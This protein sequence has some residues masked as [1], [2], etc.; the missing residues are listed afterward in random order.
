MP[1]LKFFYAPYPGDV[2]L[3]PMALVAAINTMNGR[4][5]EFVGILDTGADQSSL[6]SDLLE[7]L[8]VD[9]RYL[10]ETEVGAVGGRTPALA[11]DFIRIG[12]IDISSGKYTFLNGQDPVPLH[13]SMGPFSLVGRQSL[14]DLCVATFDGPGKIVTLDF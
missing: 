7:K 8:D 6:S 14:L 9:P 3:Q 13:F 11:C 12:L 4:H 2:T 10:T 1:R 5:S